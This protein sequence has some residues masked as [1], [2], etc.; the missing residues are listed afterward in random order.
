MGSLF[1]GPPTGERDAL[2]F[3]HLALFERTSITAR[4]P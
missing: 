3:D 2:T 1:R 4:S